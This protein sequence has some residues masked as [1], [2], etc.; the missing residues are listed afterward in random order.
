MRP[1]G[2]EGSGEEQNC[3]VCLNNIK[4]DCGAEVLGHSERLGG[5]G[6]GSETEARSHSR[7][8][9]QTES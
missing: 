6:H 9:N 3:L 2:H 1:T 5:G 7:E 4:E 8:Q